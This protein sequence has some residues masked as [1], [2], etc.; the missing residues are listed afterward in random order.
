MCALAGEPVGAALDNVTDPMEGFDIVDQSRPAKQANLSWK[1]WL[2]PG[3]APFTLNAL[4]HRRFL[5][6]DVRASAA[7]QVNSGQAAESGVLNQRDFAYQHVAELR[8]F[9]T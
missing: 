3:F 2:V 5:A 7:P 9:V 1:G 6:A 4:Q 8:I